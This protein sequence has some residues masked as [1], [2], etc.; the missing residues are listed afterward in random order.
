MLATR[1]ALVASNGGPGIIV[2][3]GATATEISY[4]RV[5][6]N[7]G[8]GL[9]LTEGTRVGE[10]LCDQFVD[11]RPATLQT[12]A[13]PFRVGDG[14][15]IYAASVDRVA[16]N[17]LSRNGRFGAVLG[18]ASARLTN[19]RGADNLYGVGNYDPRV[20]SLDASNV[21]TGRAASPAAVP[22]I[23]RGSR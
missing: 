19:N 15:S 17:E 23:T 18:Q 22:P 5:V 12:T 14:M 8:L 20:V 1:G 3:R 2:Q 11:T 4:A 7:A 13:G 6:D 21:I 9:G 16:D 10:I